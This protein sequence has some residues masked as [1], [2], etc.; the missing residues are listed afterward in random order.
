[1]NIFLECM[2][3]KEHQTLVAA[4]IHIVVNRTHPYAEKVIQPHRGFDIKATHRIVAEIEHKQGTA[5]QEHARYRVSEK[6]EIVRNSQSKQV[7]P[8]SRGE[9][10]ENATGEKSA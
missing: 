7:K 9:N 5:S 8:G 4:H 6:G 2:G 3:L 10:F 1:M